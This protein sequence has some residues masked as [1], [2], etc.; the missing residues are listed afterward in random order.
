MD[1]RTIVDPMAYH[2][3]SF[4]REGVYAHPS[5][6]RFTIVHPATGERV[7]TFHVGDAHN[8]TFAVS[9]ADRAFRE[10]GWAKA[11]RFERAGALIKLAQLLRANK[12]RLGTLEALQTGKLLS[13]CVG[14]DADRAAQNFEMFAKAVGGGDLKEEVLEQETAFLDRKGRASTTVYRNAVGVVGIIIPWNSPLMLSSWHVAPAL[15]V[16]NTVVLKLPLWAPLAVLELGKLANEA[17]IPPGVFNIIVGDKEAG[18]ALVADPR[19][20]RISFTGSVPVGKAINVANAKVRLTPPMLELGGKGANIVFSDASLDAVKGVARSIWRSQGQSCVAGSRLLLQEGIYDDFM[21]RLKDY[22]ASLRIGNHMEHGTEIGP[23]ITRKHR[24]RVMEMI[25]MAKGEGARLSHGGTVLV[26]EGCANGNFVVPT[27]FE[28][29]TPEM[30]IFQEEVFG[31]VLTVTPFADA[32]DAITLANATPFGLSSNV[33]SSDVGFAHGVAQ[34]IEAGM[35]WVNSHFVRDLRA[36]F[37]GVKDSG[38]GRAG[39]KWSLEY[40]TEPQMI[41]DFVPN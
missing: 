30:R 17:G 14:H 11:S 16:G 27:I 35:V 6:E 10:S 4:F 40:F 13:E 34:S 26:G 20:K 39:G 5:G 33:W 38:T 7:C 15:A 22:T 23:V 3:P 24:D 1:W 37:G 36:P 41:C 8:T 9:V 29:V 12:E 2:T 21:Q 18:E 32:N 25:E 19:V 31:P 28:E